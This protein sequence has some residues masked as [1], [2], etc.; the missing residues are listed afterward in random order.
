LAILENF[1]SFAA[2]LQDWDQGSYRSGLKSQ[3]ITAKY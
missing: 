3:A 1:S 2:I